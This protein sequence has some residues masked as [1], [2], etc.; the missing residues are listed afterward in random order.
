MINLRGLMS[1][2]EA[3]RGST[4]RIRIEPFQ[5]F[6]LRRRAEVA[7]QNPG[8]SNSALISLLGRMWRSLSQS[9]KEEYM[10]LAVN[11]NPAD[12]PARR[13][14]PPRRSQPHV[15]YPPPLEAI[16]LTPTEQ[17]ARPEECPQFSI[18][19]RGSSGIQ[20]A[21]V[22]NQIVFSGQPVWG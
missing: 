8:L 19:P 16:P 7:Q 2:D 18:V 1:S 6:S 17:P 14:K 5:I 13:R 4:K 9:K 11:P 20:A 10:E 21:T 22:S 3:R 12:R 15:D